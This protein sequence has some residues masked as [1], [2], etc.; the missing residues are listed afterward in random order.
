MMQRTAVSLAEALRGVATVVSEEEPYAGPTFAESPEPAEDAQVVEGDRLLARPVPATPSSGLTHFVDGAQFS[1]SAFYEGSLPGRYAFLNAGVAVRREREILELVTEE[2]SEGIFAPAGN[3]LARL[4]EVF[5]DGLSLHTVTVEETEGMAR[6]SE[7]VADAI[8][9]ERNRLELKACRDWLQSG[10]EGALLVDG[11]IGQLV[12]DTSGR[13]P[14]SVVGLVK[15]H[16]KQYFTRQTAPTI[17][18]LKEGERSSVFS[19]PSSRHSDWPRHSW[20]LR[21]RADEYKNPA[22]GLVRVELPPSD[23]SVDVADEVSGWILQE[24]SPVALPD[25]RYDRLVYPIRMVEQLLKAKQPS[26]HLVR[27]LIG[28]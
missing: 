1:C 24:R 8:S 25:A 26:R 7:R 27:S 9:A 4:R 28:A 20:Y 12:Q 16:R 21:L 11:T 17:L 2:Q 23:R 14:G 19:V 6:M 13:P 5:G 15:S 10:S 18:G 3:A 22:F